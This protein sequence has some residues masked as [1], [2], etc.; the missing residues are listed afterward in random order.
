MQRHALDL[1]RLLHFVAR[2]AGNRRDDGQ[3]RPGQ[4]V[5]QRAFAGVG[6]AGNHHLDAFAQQRALLRPLHHL[7]QRVLQFFQ[8]AAGIGLLQKVDVFLGEIQ[9]RLDQHAQV[10]QRVAQQVNL[11]RKLAR[12]RA[13]GAAGGRCRRSVNQIGN[14]LGLRQVDFVVEKRP[15]GELTRLGDAQAG[16]HLRAGLQAARQQQLQHDRA[17][18]GLQLQHVLAGVGV[19]RGKVQRQPLVNRLAVA[20]AKRQIGR[21]ARL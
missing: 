14:R 19:R 10:D 8:L 13:A 1:D 18:V 9:R 17:A 21:L 20:V 3:F 4:R 6:L 15:L 2:G 16:Q 12:Q 11:P 5:Q 7:R